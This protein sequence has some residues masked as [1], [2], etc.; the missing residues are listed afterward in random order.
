MCHLLVV[1]VL[2]DPAIS[3][4]SP[5]IMEQQE[6][7]KEMNY[8]KRNVSSEHNGVE[9]VSNVLSSK[10][11]EVSFFSFQSYSMKFMI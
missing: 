10:F 6:N 4:I 11:S 3:Q 9:I 7:L 1:N 8:Q 5:S 2:V